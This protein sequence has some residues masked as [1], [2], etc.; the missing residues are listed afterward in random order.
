MLWKQQLSG[1]A[2]MPVPWGLMVSQGLMAIRSGH[3]RQGVRMSPRRASLHCWK[4]A[5]RCFPGG[6]CWLAI[7]KGPAQPPSAAGQRISW[8]NTLSSYL[9][10]ASRPSSSFLFA[11]GNGDVLFCNT[12]SLYITWDADACHQPSS[13]M[14]NGGLLQSVTVTSTVD[15]SSIHFPWCAIIFLLIILTSY[16]G[17]SQTPSLSP[18]HIMSLVPL[19][20]VMELTVPSLLQ[21]PSV[22]SVNRV[23]CHRIFQHYLSSFLMWLLNSLTCNVCETTPKA[24]SISGG[25]T[26]KSRWTAQSQLCPGEGNQLLRVMQFLP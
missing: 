6:Y 22:V 1:F 15:S 9:E 12:C 2:D 11:F 23:G 17:F 14:A 5:S 16:A 18:A 19:L 20:W 4:G 8:W 13:T 21:L 7:S 25:R 26:R 10:S 24:S 3:T